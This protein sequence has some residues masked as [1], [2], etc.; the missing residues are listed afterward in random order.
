[1]EF[2]LNLPAP[3]ITCR[4]VTVHGD[5]CGAILPADRILVSKHLRD[6]HALGGGN[7]K[8]RVTCP[9]RDCSRHVL[10]ESL[11][12]HVLSTHL[13]L[14]TWVCPACL[15]VFARRGTAHKCQPGGEMLPH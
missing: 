2:L 11:I 3:P 10:R 15:K 12:R 4:C 5:D 7:S 6:E 9:W 13:R 14:L 1:M 8:Q